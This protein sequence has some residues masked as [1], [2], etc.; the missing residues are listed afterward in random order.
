MDA[1]ASVHCS[2]ARFMKAMS[3]MVPVGLGQSHLSSDGSG[4]LIALHIEAVSS[5]V[6]VSGSVLAC[7][8]LARSRAIDHIAMPRNVRKSQLWL[9]RYDFRVVLEQSRC[10]P[11]VMDREDAVFARLA[12]VPLYLR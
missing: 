8:V 12:T 2:D 3:H 6:Q 11:R 9:I 5:F 1:V 4:L 7:S 10:L